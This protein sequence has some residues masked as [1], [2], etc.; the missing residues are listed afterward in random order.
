MYFESPKFMFFL[1]S[2]LGELKD[3]SSLLLDSI[4]LPAS[5]DGWSKS[6]NFLSIDRSLFSESLESC[7]LSSFVLF[8]KLS[9]SLRSLSFLSDSILS[10]ICIWE[11]I[12]EI[13]KLNFFWSKI[14]LLSAFN[15]FFNLA[16]SFFLYFL[17]LLSIFLL[18]FNLK[19]SHLK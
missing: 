18:W 4:S 6:D 16:S 9:S 15:L 14:D 19:T 11:I 13:K 10:S 3:S 12:F 7:S 8:S 5:E 2:P 17:Y 1:L